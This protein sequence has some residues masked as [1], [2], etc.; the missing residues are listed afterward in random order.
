MGALFLFGCSGDKPAPTVEPHETTDVVRMDEIAAPL[1]ETGAPDDGIPAPQDLAGDDSPE[2]TEIQEPTDSSAAIDT[3]SEAEVTLGP[4]TLG[5]RGTSQDGWLP[6]PEASG[7]LRFPDGD[8]LIVSDSGNDGF[9]VLLGADG[10]MKTV[11]LPLDGPTNAQ[12]GAHTDDDLEGLD[13]GLGGKIYALTSAGWV[14]SWTR[15]GIAFTLD[16]ASYPISDDETFACATRAVN[17]GPNYEGLCLRS[18]ASAPTAVGSCDGY[19]ASKARGELVCLRWDDA[20]RLAV[21][22]EKTITLGLEVDVLSDCA[23]LPRAEGQEADVILLAGN[24]FSGSAVWLWREADGTLLPTPI[25][26]AAN[27]EALLDRG[28]GGFWSLGDLQNFSE[29]SPWLSFECGLFAAPVPT[30]TP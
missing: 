12:T 27:Q 1:D 29:E 28:A 23:F 8:S 14:R 4:P 25:A 24:L 2:P 3:G 17:C 15:A 5:C 9:A 13:L 30:S 22:P 11:R 16:G 19:A 20:G 21:V 18:G 10:V 7:A 26:G 6:L